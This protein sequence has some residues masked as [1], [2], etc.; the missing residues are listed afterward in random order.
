MGTNVEQRTR[1]SRVAGRF[2]APSF[3]ALLAASPSIAGAH[4]GSTKSIDAEVTETG[5]HV[6]V[7]IDAID[8]ALA[9]G[10]PVTAD[11]ERLLERQALLGGWLTGGLVVTADGGVCTPSAGAPTIDRTGDKPV[12]TVGVDFVCPAPATNLRL[13]DDTVFDSDPDHEVFVA[14]AGTGGSTGSVLRADSRE[15]ALSTV[16]SAWQTMKN[17]LDEGAIHLVTGYDHL[18][19]L[20]SLI[21]GAGLAAKRLGTRRALTDVAWVVTAFTIGHS[22]SLV[23]ASLG[24]VSLP[25]QL[26]ES[27]IAASIVFVAALNIA[28]PEARVARPQIAAAFGIVHGFGFSSVLADVGLPAAHRA[29]ALGAFNVGIELAQL[30]FVAIVMLPLVWAA[31]YRQYPLL[32]VRG[33]SVAIAAFGCVWLVERGLGL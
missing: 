5:A 6:D 1:I 20:L 24:I 11:P 28:K 19:F 15:V 9:V 26:V 22:I 4:M 14:V 2:L 29:L 21:L 33:G 17:F 12:V 8:A 32:V 23:L 18:L 16:P 7:R 30:A 10:L 27:V 13:R 25:A 31:K 3:A